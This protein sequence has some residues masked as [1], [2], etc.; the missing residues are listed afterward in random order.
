MKPLTKSQKQLIMLGAIMAA[1]VVVLAVYVFKPQASYVETF[2]PP[3]VDTT[4]SK[5][6]LTMP[7]YRLLSSPVVA[8]S[9]YASGTGTS[10]VVPIVPGPTGRENPFAP[11]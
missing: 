6:V 1:I 2:A 5:A 4:I 10:G 11:Y 3:T 7:E 8:P 9:G